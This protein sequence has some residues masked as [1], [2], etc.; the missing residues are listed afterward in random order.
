MLPTQLMRRVGLAC[1]MLSTIFH[2]FPP[3]DTFC[4]RSRFML[5]LILMSGHFFFLCFLYACTIFSQ[6]AVPSQEL[7][8]SCAKDGRLPGCRRIQKLQG[9]RCPKNGLRRDS[10]GQSIGVLCQMFWTWTDHG[11]SLLGKMDSYIPRSWTLWRWRWREREIYIIII[12]IIFNIYIYIY[13]Y[14]YLYIIPYLT[15]GHLTSPDHAMLCY[16]FCCAMN[17]PC[18][19]IPDGQSTQSAVGGGMQ[20]TW[21]SGNGKQAKM[22]EHLNSFCGFLPLM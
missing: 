10:W 5:G 2:L 11:W 4:Y 21:A 18:N 22:A 19:S 13:A 20:K 6:H 8:I 15:S 12:I 14:F 16:G 1:R 17:Q 3:V 9:F 7:V